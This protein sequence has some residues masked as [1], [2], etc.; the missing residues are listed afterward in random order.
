MN[1]R[2][3]LCPIK[4]EKE[5]DFT[6]K[7]DEKILFFPQYMFAKIWG[8]DNLPSRG[9]HKRVQIIPVRKSTLHTVIGSE[10]FPGPV[11]HI[12]MLPLIGSVQ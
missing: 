5:K 11:L 7:Y 4:Y 6:G 2:L 10:A 1:I 9:G 3:T 12:H 8:C